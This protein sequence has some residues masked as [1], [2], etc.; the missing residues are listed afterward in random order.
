MEQ[1]EDDLKLFHPIQEVDKKKIQEDTGVFLRPLY[2]DGGEDDAEVFPG[3][4][5]QVSYWV[6]FEVGAICCG[7]HQLAS[8]KRLDPKRQKCTADHSGVEDRKNQTR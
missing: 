7:E 3:R 1:Q 5:R 6:V 2:Q 4:Q 8:E